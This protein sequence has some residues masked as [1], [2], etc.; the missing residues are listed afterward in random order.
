MVRP[1]GESISKRARVGSAALAVLVLAVV[2]GCD[3]PRPDDRVDLEQPRAD[4]QT[5]SVEIT[6][7]MDEFLF[8]PATLRLPAGR[9]V[10][11]SLHNRGEVPHEFMAGR[12]A[13]D[14]KFAEDLLAGVDVRVV[15]RAPSDQVVA[16]E[17]TQDN[18]AAAVH[19]DTHGA[20]VLVAPGRK[21]TVVFTL[22]AHRRGEWQI[23]CFLPG[24]YEAGMSG[25]LTVD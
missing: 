8:S 3:S 19:D 15:E 14:G 2:G 9:P 12:A 7:E 22:P 6:L 21:K 13:A 24:H 23:A 25:A 1:I 5:D 18:M 4:A 10:K 11:L 17:R 20:M 16:G